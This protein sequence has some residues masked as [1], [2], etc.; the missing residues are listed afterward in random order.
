[1]SFTKFKFRNQLLFSLLFVFIPLFITGAVVAYYQG[2][3]ILKRNIEAGLND[4]ADI[5]L[6]FTKT[7]ALDSI[8]NRLQAVSEQNLD[9]A[10][11]YF[12]R[13]QEGFLSKEKVIEAIED[14][15]LGRSIGRTGYIY[16]LDSKG[17]VLI[18]PDSRLKGVNAAKLDLVK[19]QISNR[20]GYLD[21]K[22]KTPGESNE[23]AKV[24][25]MA[26]FKP[27][28][29][30]ICLVVLKEEFAELANTEMFRKN[31]LAFRSGE[32]GYAYIIQEDGMLLVHP[33]LPKINFFQ[34][35]AYP[36][37]FMEDIIEKKSGKVEYEWQN[38]GELTFRS[39]VVF[40]RH[41]PEFKWIVVSSDYVSEVY[42]PLKTA[43][44]IFWV[45][46]I[47]FILSSI[48]FAVLISSFVSRPL[49]TIVDQLKN[50][51]QEGSGV[52]LKQEDGP[53][54]IEA[55]SR[56]FQ[57]FMKQME[58]ARIELNQV[59]E[60]NLESQT[61]LVENDLKLRSLFDQSFQYIGILSPF[62]VLEQMN[63]SMADFSSAAMENVLFKPFWEADWWDHDPE[64]RL[65]IK[66]SVKK[67]MQGEFVRY[68][69]TAVSKGE[70][71]RYLDL[72]I[73]PVLNPSDEVAFII[74]ESRDITDFRQAAMEKR[75]L[76]V[77][78]ER[79]QKME[80]IGTL[81][82]GIAHDFNNILSGILGYSQ[83]LEMSLDSRE[84]AK[85]H[86]REIAQ[87][88][89]RAAELI[90]QILT[91]SRKT[92]FKKQPLRLY[93][94]IKEAL[95]LMRSTIP[96]T[97]DIDEFIYSKEKVLADPT[98]MHQV[99]MN[100]CTNAYH[101]MST[102]G[103]VL[104][105]KLRRCK[106]SDRKDIFDKDMIAGD[107]L[108]LEVGDTGQGMD[109]EVMAKAFDPYFTTKDLGKGT[110]FG[111]A[112]VHAIIDEHEGYIDLKTEMGKGTRLFVY[113]P[114]EKD[115]TD[116]NQDQ[117]GQEV[118]RGGNE[119]IMVVDDEEGIR[120]VM[121]LFLENLGYTVAV[122]EN[123]G[124]ALEAFETDPYLY[125]LVITDMTMPKIT[126]DELS[127]KMLQSR[128]DIPIIL[129]TGYSE[130]VSEEHCR[131]IGIKEYTYKPVNNK[132]LAVLI[133]TFLDEK[134][135]S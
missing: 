9:I 52:N 128:S 123:G 105:V 46:V 133:R 34:Q 115:A 33:T 76:A 4:R 48:L 122:F 135:N 40:F 119:V 125:D 90:Q 18:H 38:P 85:E 31:I 64:V 104:T 77:Q 74:A 1:M 60:K 97:I 55:L 66:K 84:K 20:E 98:Q 73:K 110:G 35:S 69:T 47:I 65:E 42:A 17:H 113:L 117:E 112:L 86:I 107:Y 71:I 134:K 57:S 44:N 21:T 30:I 92:E 87:G 11:Y 61:A 2:S 43:K 121:S 91:F 72:S 51:D 106:I 96:S 54:E 83:L 12:K 67:A 13:F 80:A 27:L 15:F 45:S 103:G 108:E 59:I 63:Q 118:L 127:I 24:I 120:N 79:A 53:V 29:L 28:D 78:L 56:S 124:Q 32:S 94:V 23:K 62:G 114:V 7:S 130:S 8:K 88:A 99:I 14:I 10:A 22:L 100:L 95:K 6:N 93:L 58:Q 49:E 89:N 101:A 39:K 126:G 26:Y 116:S 68:E 70:R 131:E 5:L 82:G 75:D 111:L 16:C 25:Q 81:A 50:G 129:C 19:E 36:N 41:L 109:N 132:K 37:H 3:K 102:T